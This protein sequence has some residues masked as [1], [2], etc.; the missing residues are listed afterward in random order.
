MYMYICICIYTCIPIYIYLYIPIYTYI[1]LY[2]YIPIYLY[3]G[4][5]VDVFFCFFRFRA[6]EGSLM[7]PRA[8]KSARNTIYISSTCRGA[9]GD[10][11]IASHN[12]PSRALRPINSS[13]GPCTHHSASKGHDHQAPLIYSLIFIYVYRLVLVLVLV[14]VFVLLVVLFLSILLLLVVVLVAV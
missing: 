1:Y 12:S 6:Q 9:R 13:S 4:V 2:T 8:E 7:L 10:L 14:V 5:F 3:I 11:D